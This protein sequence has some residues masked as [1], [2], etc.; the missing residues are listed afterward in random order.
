MT[1]PEPDRWEDAEPAIQ[2]FWNA[3]QATLYRRWEEVRDYYRFGWEWARS[4]TYTGLTFEQAEPDLRRMWE[5]LKPEGQPPLGGDQGPG[6]GRLEEGPRR[7][8]GARLAKNHVVA[9]EA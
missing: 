9:A 3:N 7:L 4:R 2:R 6:K 8:L 5:Q 1:W